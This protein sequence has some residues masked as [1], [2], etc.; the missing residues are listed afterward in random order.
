MIHNNENLVQWR[1]ITAED[2]VRHKVRSTY[3]IKRHMHRKRE[4]KGVCVCACVC[5]CLF[6]GEKKKV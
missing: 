1:Q 5:V 2:T 4:R 3:T 6:V